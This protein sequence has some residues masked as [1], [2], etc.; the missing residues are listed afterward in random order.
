MLVGIMFFL[1]AGRAERGHSAA[2]WLAVVGGLS[3]HVDSRRCPGCVRNPHE[4]RIEG[5]PAG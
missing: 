5:A 3:E 4:R 2:K 1:W